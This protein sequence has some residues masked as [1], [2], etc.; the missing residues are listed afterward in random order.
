VPSWQT[1][2]VVEPGGTTTVVFAGEAGTT[3]VV[4]SG[5]GGLLLLTQPESAIAVSINAERIFMITPQSSNE[6]AV[7]SGGPSALA[8]WACG[9]R[10]H[11]TIAHH[12]VVRRLQLIFFG[13]GHISGIDYARGQDVRI[14]GGWL[15]LE[16]NG[17]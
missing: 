6:D 1:T 3:T 9:V 16:R 5:G 2:V 8:G 15:R 14:I 7:D 17:Y 12:A 11:R 10:T 4:F 13:H